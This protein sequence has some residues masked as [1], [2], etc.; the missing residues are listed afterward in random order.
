MLKNLYLLF[1]LLFLNIL[2]GFGQ[3]TAPLLTREPYLQ[4]VT[5]T[6]IIIRWRTDQATTG[7]VWL[8]IAAN[9]LTQTV[10]E[11]Q[12]TT[13]HIVS[14]T[15][16]QSA[17]RY[18]YAVGQ[19]DTRLTTGNDYTFKTALPTGDRRPFRIWALGDFGCGT[20]NQFAAY[21]Q[22][23]KFTTDKPSDVWLWLG[24]N[25]YCC[26]YDEQ[27]QQFV[28]NVYGSTLRNLPF[29]PVPGNHDYANNADVRDLP[30][31]Q[32]FNFPQLAEAGGT[33]SG[34]KLYYSYDYG[35]VHFVALDSYGIEAGLWRLADT[36]GTQV[37]W[38]KRDLA[39]T[40][41]PWKVVYFHH[42]PYS[43]GSHNSD[44]DPELIPLHEKL[45]QV[46][47]SYGVDLVLSGHSHLYERS[48]RLRGHTGPSTSLA[49]QQHF[50]E[51][52]TARYD[53]SPNSCPILTKGLGTVYIVAG[54]GGQMDQ[55]V[56]PDY[57]HTAMAY[58]NTSVGG[59]VVMDVND[60]RLDVQWLASDGLVRDRFTIL[61]N[62][63]RSQALALEYGDNA[64]LSASW[65]GEYRWSGGQ[66]SRVIS[67]TPL[68]TAIF[69]VTDPQNCLRDELTVNVLPKPRLVTAPPTTTT[70]CAGAIIPISFT[71][72]NTSRADA[73]QYDVQLSDASGRFDQQLVIGNGPRN[74]LRA[75]IPT[76]LP[77]GTGYRLRVMA[78]SVS[79]AEA[80]ESATF[81]IRPLPTATVTGSSTIL[82]GNSTPLTLAFTGD[83]P[84][85]GSLTDGTS[86]S[87]TTSPLTLVVQPRE[88]TTFQV[89]SV[90]NSCGT[91]NGIG[92]ALVMVQLA[93]GVD[94][95][96]GGKLTLF[97]NPTLGQITVDVSLPQP[98]AVTLTVY[99]T[100]GRLIQ[101]RLL[102]KASNHQALLTLPG[103]AGNY[104]IGIEAGGKRITRR[105]MRL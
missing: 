47:E 55:V 79:F 34:T 96:D 102:K 81:T 37:Q 39:A 59:S 17:T 62:T 5:P 6:S 14:L 82:Q 58:S 4:V 95:F 77:A 7:K 90:V 9:Q 66:N 105:V 87:A 15:G 93:L 16:L 38:L 44:T 8:G 92:Q 43:K 2:P 24:D 45:T 104:L 78:K 63:N 73:W 86:F 40:R 72:Q 64:Q 68:Q 46:L 49:P 53:G 50:A 67:V 30:Y 56:S 97:P 33:A 89:K 74:G 12:P 41:Q 18:Y 69:T 27:F 80:V 42:P 61:K 23:K 20:D 10:S 88:T 48:Y 36:T 60:N 26:G 13:E 65:P 31:F 75:T 98:Q 83:G 29:Y 19:Q 91:G 54:S 3:S 11:A 35:N 103:V 84:W 32:L 70:L 71:A 1:C 21:D 76:N 85:N 52:T 57:P 28:F 100:Q 101:T 25:A 51:N 22:Y 99:D 94:E